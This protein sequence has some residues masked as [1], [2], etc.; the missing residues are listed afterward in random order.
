MADSD[1][2]VEPVRGLPEALPA[3][4][5]ILWQG[6][7]S[8][9]G[10]ARHAFLARLVGIY[11]ALMTAWIFAD[12]LL[13][14]GSAVLAIRDCGPMALTGLAAVAIL[15]LLGRLQARETVYTLTN[16]RVVLRI[17]VA[18]TAVVNVP[19]NEVV[20][21]SLCRR[22]HGR[23]DIPMV[24]KRKGKRPL[25]YLLLWPH[26]RPWHM[27]EPQPM[28]RAIPEAET[29]ATILV[30]ALGATREHRSENAVLASDSEIRQ[31]GRQPTVTPA[32]QILPAE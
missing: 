24:L 8:A 3:G 9:W 21:V 18:T 31:T 13:D 17:G 6:R 22:E 4:E 1:I 16:R 27:R 30:A 23:G 32:G 7:P 5:R 11:F 12:T 29:V 10:L 15:Y 19:L 25:P 28:L 20:G 26:V 2:T 14:G